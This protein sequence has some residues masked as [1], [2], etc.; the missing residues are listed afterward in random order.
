MIVVSVVT[1]TPVNGSSSRMTRLRWA[2]A[3]ARK[4]RFLLSAGQL[5]DLALAKFQHPHPRQALLGDAPV[6]RAWAAQEVH[7]AVAAHQHHIPHAHREGPVHLLRLR[8]I[9]DEIGL[10]RR[11]HGPTG[12]EH[13]A[14][15]RAHEV[16]DG[17]EKRGLAAAVHAD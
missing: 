14:A 9:G 8:H 4:T 16:H 2:S 10:E 13:G 12:D 11:A 3:R 5:A 15:D 17:F 7:V 6:L 1:S